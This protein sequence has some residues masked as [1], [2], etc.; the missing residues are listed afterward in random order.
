[1]ARREYPA[2]ELVQKLIGK[3]ATFEK[4]SE[5]VQDLQNQNLVS[6]ERFAE[7]LIRVRTNRGYGPL[8]IAADLRNRGVSSEM[9]SECI[10]IEDPHW[11]DR[12]AIVVTKKYRNKPVQ[13]FSEWAKRANFLK[14]RGYTSAQINQVLGKYSDSK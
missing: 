4:A 7:Q 2:T 14:N 3:G 12:L 1:M 13:S 6:D 8:R 9:I 5:V 11:N 10:D